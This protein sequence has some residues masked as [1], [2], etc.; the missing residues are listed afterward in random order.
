MNGPKLYSADARRSAL[1]NGEA[2]RS[3]HF[4]N[5][6]NKILALLKDVDIG[7]GRAES[8]EAGN[9]IQFVVHN[10]CA[11]PTS[12]YRCMPDIVVSRAAFISPLYAN[13]Q[14]PSDSGAQGDHQR[15]DQ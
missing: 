9:E 10:S 12:R 1:A 14:L 4:V 7:G 2:E 8:T 13:I 5:A 11:I 6:A 15:D 3:C